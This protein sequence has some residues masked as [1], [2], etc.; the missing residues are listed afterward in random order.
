MLAIRPLGA[1]ILRAT[2]RLESATFVLLCFR[3]TGSSPSIDPPPM[4]SSLP[5][6][7]LDDDDNFRVVS[8]ALNFSIP[9]EEDSFER[10]E[11]SKEE[12]DDVSESTIELFRKSGRGSEE[13][14]LGDVWLRLRNGDCRCGGKFP[15]WASC[16]LM[17][18]QF[19]G[20]GEQPSDGTSLSKPFN[21]SASK[22]PDVIVEVSRRS[23]SSDILGD[24]KSL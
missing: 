3:T 14:A 23:P 12:R 1:S 15:S 5:S 10:K 22:L 7:S 24:H 9:S 13:N 11:P 2:G 21:G 8:R 18:E 4:V 17:N 16:S 20:A 6:E 19:D